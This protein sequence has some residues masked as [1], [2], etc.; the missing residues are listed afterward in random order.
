MQSLSQMLSSTLEWK[1][2]RTTRTWILTCLCLN[3]TL[4]AKTGGRQDWPVGLV[5][6]TRDERKG[7]DARQGPDHAELWSQRVNTGRWPG[8]EPKSFRSKNKVSCFSVTS[9][10]VLYKIMA[11]CHYFLP[12][13]TSSCI[14]H[15][16]VKSI[17]F[18]DTQNLFW[19]EFC[20]LLAVW[21]SSK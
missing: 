16:M 9:C 7:L 4:L 19:P 1:Q 10:C 11:L 17:G 12:L 2:Q 20:L 15:I 8:F 14:Q 6:W 5:R 13:H 3:K 21:L 18:R